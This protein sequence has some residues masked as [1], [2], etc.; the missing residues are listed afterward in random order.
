MKLTPQ[1]LI[2]LPGYGMAEKHLRET[3]RWE[4]S[5]VERAASS[6]AKLGQYLEDASGAL[7]D[8]DYAIDDALSE[9]RN[10]AKE[11]K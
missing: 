4:L 7:R 5:D 11:A 3:G 9:Y 10:I 6:F 2:D 1:Q 8:A